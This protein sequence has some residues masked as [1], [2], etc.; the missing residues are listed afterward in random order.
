MKFYTTEEVAEML[1]VD[2]VSVRRL[3]Q[4]KKIKAHKVVSAWRIKESD[5]EAYINKETNI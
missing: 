4:N 2:V 1:K 5:L 3:I